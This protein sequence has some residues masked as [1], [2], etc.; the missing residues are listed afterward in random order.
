M[1]GFQLWTMLATTSVWMDPAGPSPSAATVRPPACGPVG[2]VGSLPP[3]EIG[4][5]STPGLELEVCTG[6]AACTAV[7]LFW[8]CAVSVR[9]L[10]GYCC[11]AH[12][13]E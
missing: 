5:R 10:F 12:L 2:N 7:A 3:L 4:E 11:V 1:S 9:V 8:I 6:T 13:K